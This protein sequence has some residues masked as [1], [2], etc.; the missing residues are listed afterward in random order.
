MLPESLRHRL[1]DVH[2]CAGV[3]PVFAGLHRFT[4]IRQDG[5]SPRSYRET[6]HV[7]YPFHQPLPASRRATTIVIPGKIAVAQVVHEL[8]HVLH[9]QVDFLP[10]AKPVSDYATLNN[11][12]A[13]AEAFAAWVLP[14]WYS[15]GKAKDRLH[16]EDPRLVA[17]FAELGDTTALQGAAV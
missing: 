6:A 16:Q 2:I 10:D 5:F 3:D 14:Y 8:G 4:D 7:A 1:G 11:G 9:E 13:F 12:E 15:Y 17:L